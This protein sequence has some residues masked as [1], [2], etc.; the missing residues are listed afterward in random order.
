[1]SVLIALIASLL[2][3]E[4]ALEQIL[5]LRITNPRLESN[6]SDKSI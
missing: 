5:L 1:M 3:R 2:S 6:E 4:E